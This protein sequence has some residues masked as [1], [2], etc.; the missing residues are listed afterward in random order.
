TQTQLLSSLNDKRPEIVR[1]VAEV[2]SYMNGEQVQ[3]A[4]LTR[5][6]DEKTPDE[7]KV[8]VLRSLAMNAK[9]YGNHLN[10]QQIG[11]LQKAVES[12]QNLDVRTAAAEARGAL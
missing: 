3:P 8:S 11:D 12:V 9:F 5:G 4:L 7:V 1:A 6:L 2:L 10:E